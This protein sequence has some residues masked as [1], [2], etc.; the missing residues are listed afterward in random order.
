MLSSRSYFVDW[1]LDLPLNSFKTKAAGFCKCST[2]FFTVRESNDRQTFDC[3]NSIKFEASLFAKH[4]TYQTV[5]KCINASIVILPIEK[6]KLL[7][8]AYSA[9]RCC[10]CQVQGNDSQTVDGNNSVKSKTTFVG[11]RMTYLTLNEWVRCDFAEWKRKL[12]SLCLSIYCCGHHFQVFCQ[13]FSHPKNSKDHPTVD[14]KNSAK[15]RANLLAEHWMHWT[16][17]SNVSAFAVSFADPQRGGYKFCSL[18]GSVGELS[19]DKL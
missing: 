16:P 13:S 9:R 5:N 2:K 3:M 8:Q 4:W 1:E 12:N 15:C 18:L 17:T 19:G 6:Y 7:N 14:R 11:A 10:W